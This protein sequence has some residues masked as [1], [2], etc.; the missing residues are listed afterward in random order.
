MN[1]TVKKQCPWKILLGDWNTMTLIT[2]AVGAIVFGLLSVFGD[3]SVFGRFRFPTAMLIPV[4]VGGI[5]GTL[6]AF[7]IV[8]IG[9][10]ASNFLRVSGFWFDMTMS[11]AVLG[12][13]IGMLPLYGAKISEGIFTVKHAAIFAVCCLIGQAVAF[14]VVFPIL[15]SVFRPDY[16][17]GI[18]PVQAFINGLYTTTTLV[19][20]GIL[21]LSLMAKLYRKKTKTV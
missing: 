12:L 6:P 7:F 19:I 4:A 15:A 14:G 9:S 5:Y 11:Y 13:F 16:F 1:E 18:Y 8:F 10:L 20:S 17:F 2:V 3:F 21:L